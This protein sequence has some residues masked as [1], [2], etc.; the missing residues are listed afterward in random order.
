MDVWQMNMPEELSMPVQRALRTMV[1]G[2]MLVQCFTVYVYLAAYI[3]LLYPE[4]RPTLVLPWLLL[5]AI[6]KLLCELTSLA[7]GLGTCVL[8]G[9]ARTPCIK[10]VV[11]KFTTIMPAF[12]MWMLVFSY[13]HALKVATA[14]KTFPAVLPP[15]DNDY[16]LE[17]A[18]RRRR[19][20]SLLGE[21]QLRK[22]LV[23]SLY[24]ERLCVT[25]DT[26]LR[27]Q[28]DL[29][30]RM[31]HSTDTSVEEDVPEPDVMKPSTTGWSDSG[32][33]EDWFGS[34]IIIPRDTDRILEQI[35]LMLL[36][37]SAYMKKEGTESMIDPEKFSS[38]VPPLWH[39][40]NIECTINSDD[41]DTPQNVG[42]SRGNTASYL[43][44]YPQIFMKKPA[45]EKLQSEPVIAP[46]K[47]VRSYGGTDE[48]KHKTKRNTPTV[49]HETISISVELEP[50]PSKKKVTSPDINT[51]QVSQSNHAPLIE[52]AKVKSKFDKQE[53][54][55][56]PF[57]IR[58]SEISNK[59]DNSEQVSEVLPE[60]N[61]NKSLN[62]N[63]N[64]SERPNGINNH[65]NKIDD[66]EK[67]TQL[68]I[69][70]KDS[71]KSIALITQ[72]ETQNRETNL[73]FLEEY[74]NMVYNK[75]MTSNN[76]SREISDDLIIHEFDELIN[77]RS[78]LSQ[79]L[80]IE[81]NGEFLVNIVANELKE[82][83]LF[84][85]ETSHT[86]SDGDLIDSNSKDLEYP[87]IFNLDS[88]ENFMFRKV[89]NENSIDMEISVKTTNEDVNSSNKT[90]KDEP[91]SNLNWRELATVSLRDDNEIDREMKRESSGIKIS[92][93]DTIN[94]LIDKNENLNQGMKIE[95]FI[96][97]MI[98]EEIIDKQVFK[99]NKAK[100]VPLRI[101]SNEDN[102]DPET[103]TSNTTTVDKGNEVIPKESEQNTSQCN[104]N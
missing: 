99:Y 7:L 74:K 16:G 26:Y 40:D 31:V 70:S 101:M 95:Y 25:N 50:K 102:L 55:K 92:S 30:S 17:L 66:D 11:V 68:L 38:V 81:C 14:F 1:S 59:T 72:T 13:Y 57:Q 9:P 39:R 98:I 75:I 63:L 10:F 73:K 28:H 15:S 77:D 21:D 84:G 60:D 69:P 96:Q 78:T 19:T 22:K 33:Y 49:S 45:T 53:Q 41:T 37:V 90:C 20:K 88:E 71:E 56:M 94:N 44:D 12:Y 91:E 67:N 2:V 18:V 58:N 76:N 51:E 79:I 47:T 36:R 83:H 100:E 54:V 87:Q 42:S 27:P 5:A 85:S 52:A 62:D 29:S 80:N 24:G 64:Q 6:R 4:E 89:S 93:N 8:L 86:S 104:L 23:A 65:N 32:A 43:R 46:L 103:T 97:G 34:E 48:F 82:R 35:V 3:V 61:T